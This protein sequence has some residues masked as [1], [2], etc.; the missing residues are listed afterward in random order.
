MRFLHQYIDTFK[1]LSK[2]IWFLALVTLVNR[3]GTMIIPFLALYL[4]ND[5]GFTKSQV[6][7]IWTVFGLGSL[8]GSWLGGKLADKIGYYPVMVI[9]LIATGFLF[10]ALQLLKSFES[11]CLGIFLIMLIAD[12][13]RPASFTAISV[14]SKPK[15][16]TRSI[17]LI[18]LAIN[19]GMA[20]GPAV[21]GLIIVSMGY[22]GLF[23]IDGITCIV[24]GLMIVALLKPKVINKKVTEKADILKERLKSLPAHKDGLYLLFLFVLFLIGFVFMQ[25]F[26]TLP[27]FYE[28][29]HLMN[30][31]EI[32]WLIM[33]N[34]LLIFFLEM[35][36]VTYFDSRDIA[37]VTILQYAIVLLALSYLVLVFE[38]LFIVV[39]IGMILIT[40]GEM[41]VFPFA[42]TY[43]MNWAPKER[44]GEY[45][46]LFTMAFSLANI[47]GPNIGVQVADQFGYNTCWYMLSAVSLLALFLAG[48]LKHLIAKRNFLFE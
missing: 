24:G 45:L 5:L 26:S 13:F 10:I 28:E 25:L 41:L 46:G 17:T 30:E 29:V 35:P 12:T 9:S 7:W 27:L 3:A 32:G 6:G 44:S 47:V 43:A 20:F 11:F 38:A 42:N 34:G 21:G 1:G 22:G 37:K 16:R 31:A 2:Q 8:C 19:L 23:W 33:M 39:I 18:R 14:Y 40:V 15:N 48:V 4:T 36:L